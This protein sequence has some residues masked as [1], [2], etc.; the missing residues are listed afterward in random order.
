PGTRLEAWELASKPQ[1]RL[2]KL[3]RADGSVQFSGRARAV[4]PITTESW[5][6]VGEQVKLWRE[7]HPPLALGRPSCESRF[8]R[9]GDWL[10]GSVQDGTAWVI[11]LSNPERTFT[12]ATEAGGDVTAA[13]VGP[14]IAVEQDVDAGVRTQF[15][16]PEDMT[17]PDSQVWTPPDSL[18]GPELSFSYLKK[19]GGVLLRRSVYSDA[20]APVR[21]WLIEAIQLDSEKRLASLVMPVSVVTLPAATLD[22]RFG[23]VVAGEGRDVRVAAFG[24][25]SAR[26]L[27]AEEMVGQITHIATPDGLVCTNQVYIRYYSCAMHVTADLT[28]AGRQRA[29]NRFCLNSAAG[30]WSGVVTPEPGLVH[31]GSGGANVSE[32]CGERMAADGSMAAFLEVKPKR[33][34][35]GPYAGAVVV[36]IDTKTGRRLRRLRVPGK[37]FDPQ[38]FIDV[39]FSPDGAFVGVLFNRLAQVY[40]LSD[41]ARVGQDLPADGWRA[42]AWLS[43]SA[44][45]GGNTGDPVAELQGDAFRFP[46]TAPGSRAERCV[47]GELVTPA[48]VCTA[49]EHTAQEH[50]AQEHT[51]QE[52]AV[53]EQS[54]EKSQP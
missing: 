19:W 1:Q 46:S 24:G 44:F 35:E 45:S 15:I 21:G 43:S 29:A 30:P 25:N 26:K 32:V 50:T 5:L 18:A 42:F 10:I 36:V 51:A 6:V 40:R 28:G 13:R 31:I 17:D 8:R 11:N 3:F 22:P 49:Q 53:P 9:L 16:F 4:W 37:M 12:R 38:P 34:A 20:A 54:A 7:K 23:L 48:E 47:F 41:G 39:S 52:H 33:G 27:P 14:Y 2:W